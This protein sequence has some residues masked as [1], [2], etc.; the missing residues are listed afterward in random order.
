M[1]ETFWGMFF[2]VAIIAI[3]ISAGATI[4]KVAEGAKEC[5]VDSD[6]GTNRYCGSDF[7]C[8]SFPAIENTIVKTDW[9]T[10]SIIIGLSIVLA[11]LILRKKQTPPKRPFY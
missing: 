1:A 8:H 7:K 5:K 2:V 4:L 3:G 10:P 11:A 9:T 6:C